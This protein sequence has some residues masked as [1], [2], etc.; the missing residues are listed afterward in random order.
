MVLQSMPVSC[1]FRGCKAPLSRIVSGAISSELPLLSQNK[2]EYVNCTAV[3]CGSWGGC[4]PCCHSSSIAFLGFVVFLCVVI[5]HCVWCH[6]LTVLSISFFRFYYY[7]V[8]HLSSYITVYDMYVLPFGIVK[9]NNNSQNVVL[10]F[11]PVSYVQ[12]FRSQN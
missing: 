2:C 3:C 12:F 5:L 9:N 6:M 11:F 4:R 1:H 7:L 8:V 10:H